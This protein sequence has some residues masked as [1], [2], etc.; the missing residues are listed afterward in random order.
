MISHRHEPHV[1][2][3]QQKWVS[4]KCY[5]SFVLKESKFRYGQFPPGLLLFTMDTDITPGM[6]F[7]EN[8]GTA[9]TSRVL[10]CDT[11]GLG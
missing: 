4:V 5:A 9:T 11:K 7:K 1:P 10:V 8:R 3:R 6:M 2:S